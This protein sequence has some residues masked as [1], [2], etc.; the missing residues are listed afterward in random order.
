MTIYRL[1]TGSSQRPG[2][3]KPWK[4]AKADFHTLE[5]ITVW[6]QRLVV[7]KGEIKR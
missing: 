3:S 7:R 6:K 2:L 4:H 5:V 1:P